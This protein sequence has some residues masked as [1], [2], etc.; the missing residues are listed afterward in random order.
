MTLA[1]ILG[2]ACLLLITLLALLYSAW[3]GWLK[4]LLIVSVTALYFVGYET[5]HA[6]WGLPSTD[7]LP[8]RFVML[9]ALIDEPTQKT[10]GALYIWVSPLRED[11]PALAPRAYRLPYSKTLH[12]QLD[13][14]MKRG[15]D[16]VNQMG[17]A[18]IKAGSGRGL[19]WLR[20]G[21]DEQEIKIRD[22][23]LKQL[24]EK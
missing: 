7:P 16:G 22:L 15:R 11:Q 5:V 19:G 8:E 10:A 23:P 14:G 9:S 6:I 17:T 24:P 13:N 2:Y 1:L 20:P 12:E 21:S 4:G 3:P 18:E